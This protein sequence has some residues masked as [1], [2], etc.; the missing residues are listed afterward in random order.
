MQK[1]LA[2]CACGIFMTFI[3]LAQG[4]RFVSAA[5]WQEVLDKARA[6]NKYIFLDCYATWCAPCKE[7]DETVYPDEGLG[8]FLNDKVIAVKVQIDSTAKDAEIIKQWYKDARMIRE[9]YEIKSLPTL[10]FFNPEGSPVHYAT[11]FKDVENLKELTTDALNPGKQFYT[12]MEK[13]KKAKATPSQ[14]MYIARYARSVQE[15]ELAKKIAEKYIGKLSQ[16]QMLEKE[17]L[18]F[19]REFTWSTNDRGFK[20]F[21]NHPGKVDGVLGPNTAEESRRGVISGQVISQLRKNKGKADYARIE[22]E[23]VDRFGETGARAVYSALAGY[24]WEIGD[25]DNFV[26]YKDKTHVKWAKDISYFYM[27]N[28]AWWVFE[29]TGDKKNLE[30]ALAWQ[31]K[32]IEGDKED[33]SILDTYANI[34]YRMGRSDEAIQ[35]EEKAVKLENENALQSNRKRDPVY[36]TTLTKMKAGVPT[37]PQQ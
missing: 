2:L 34:L 1:K 11:G 12:L 26:K 36:E 3:S 32:V 19:I 7:M 30:S 35:Y 16:K 27:N 28:D 29:R 24:A 21:T 4:V 9:K 22:K 18:A 10:L 25:V 20:L 23:T 13:Y 5:S 17:N 15:M 14:I 37:W 6:A 31:K 33:P 8:T